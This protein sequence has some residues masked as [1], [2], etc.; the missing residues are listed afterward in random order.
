MRKG[1]GRKIEWIGDMNSLRFVFFGG[2]FVI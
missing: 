2:D 1:K